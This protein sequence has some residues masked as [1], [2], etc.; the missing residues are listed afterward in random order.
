MDGGFTAMPVEIPAGGTIAATDLGP[1]HLWLLTCPTDVPVDRDRPALLTRVTL[2]D[3]AVRRWTVPGTCSGP[4]SNSVGLGSGML[5]VD[6]AG[7]VW[8]LPGGRLT[9]FDPLNERFDTWEVPKPS[10]F[11]SG[12]AGR[13]FPAALTIG[14]GNIVWICY[15]GSQFLQGFDPESQRWRSI[16]IHPAVCGGGMIDALPG[17]KIAVTGFRLGDSGESRVPRLSVIDTGSGI[18]EPTGQAARL[19]GVLTDGSIAYPD[20]SGRIIMFDA[21]TRRSRQSTMRVHSMPGVPGPHHPRIFPGPDGSTW[22]VDLSQ[23]EEGDVALVGYDAGGVMQRRLPLPNVR[24]VS[25]S[26][27]TRWVWPVGPVFVG[28][29]NLWLVGASSNSEGETVTSIY[30]ASLSPRA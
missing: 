25:N 5:S 20:D 3:S 14:P 24:R 21:R 10:A 11:V 6:G 29:S 23:A 16:P 8:G 22:F 15:S 27:G 17:G 12:S 7:R 18:A 13:P 9:V 26:A 1:A 28:R 4:T 19:F 2:A 30:T